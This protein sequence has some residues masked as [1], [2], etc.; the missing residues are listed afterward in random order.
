MIIKI[1]LVYRNEHKI[2]MR[3]YTGR[4]TNRSALR[5]IA[6][7]MYVIEKNYAHEKN[8]GFPVVWVPYH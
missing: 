5:F 6:N 2:P 8:I 1:N 3:M 4:W 7:S